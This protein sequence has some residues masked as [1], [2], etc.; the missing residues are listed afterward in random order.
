MPRSRSIDSTTSWVKAKKVLYRSFREKYPDVPSHYIH[1]AIR[2][3]SQRLK[4]FEKLKKRGVAR[5]EKP[6]VKRWSVGC[7]SQLWKLTLEGVRIATHNGW[8]GIPIHFHIHFH[9]QFW[10]YC[11]NGWTAN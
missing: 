8:I 4:S 7:D 9:K 10:K 2:D 3:A 1:E 5:T 11:N 6:V